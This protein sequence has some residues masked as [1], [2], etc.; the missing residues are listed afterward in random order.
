MLQTLS[1]KEESNYE[2]DECDE[3]DSFWFQ[4]TLII[5]IKISIFQENILLSTGPWMGAENEPLCTD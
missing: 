5:L 1:S 2:T 4:Q 3:N